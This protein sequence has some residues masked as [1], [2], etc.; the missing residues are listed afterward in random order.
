MSPLVYQPPTGARVARQRCNT[1]L[2]EIPRLVF[3]INQQ[4]MPIMGYEWPYTP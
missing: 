2:E 1:F 3:G 4:C